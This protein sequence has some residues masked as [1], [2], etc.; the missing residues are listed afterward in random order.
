MYINIYVQG[1]SSS[2]G[3]SWPNSDSTYTR[4]FLHYDS[5]STTLG[6]FVYVHVWVWPVRS[7]SMGHQFC[8][9]IWQTWVGGVYSYVY[10]VHIH[11]Y[12]YMYT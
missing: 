2:L 8:A 12:V 10:V 3:G 11:T 7:L 4:A 5:V 9:A 6:M 1:Q